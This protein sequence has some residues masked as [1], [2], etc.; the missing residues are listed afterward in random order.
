MKHPSLILSLTLFLFSC[1]QERKPDIYEDD[2]TKIKYEKNLDMVQQKREIIL[3]QQHFDIS[4]LKDESKLL[5]ENTLKLKHL[6]K[7]KS[8]HGNT[9]IKRKLKRRRKRKPKPSTSGDSH[10]GRKIYYFTTKVSSESNLE[11]AG[12]TRSTKEQIHITVGKQ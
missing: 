1:G 12:S 3:Q 7:E 5:K 8:S 6:I 9:R 4:T 2:H 11:S 10:R